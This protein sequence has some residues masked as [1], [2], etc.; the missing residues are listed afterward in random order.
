MKNYII[1]FTLCVLTFFSCKKDSSIETTSTSAFS[2][3]ST[4]GVYIS[5]EGLF[6]NGNGSVS[7]YS[8]SGTESIKDVYQQVNNTQLGDVVQSLAKV[9]NKLYIVVNNSSKIEV[10][11]ITTMKKTATISGLTSPRY[12]LP[13]NASK[14]YVTDLFSGS[15]SIVDLN[16][17]LVTGHISLN[18][19]TEQLIMYNGKVYVTNMSTSYLYVIN[20]TTDNVSDS[21]LIGTGGNSIVM[22]KN[23]KLWILCGGD[24]NLNIT[25][26]LHRVDPI[27]Q[28]DEF[29]VDFPAATF[30]NRLTINEAKD[31]LY[32][33]NY[34]LYR[35]NILDTTLPGSEFIAAN[36]KNFYGLG[37]NNT[38]NQIY[39]SDGVDFQQAGRVYRYNESGTE[40][41][42]FGAGIIPGN[43]LFLGN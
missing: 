39:V 20:P 11:D 12:L 10:V 40:L 41:G 16:T 2:A 15:V 1:L 5:N 14:A 37:F 27:T 25:S 6:N 22:D 31:E 21:I 28:I 34:N 18:G 8:G 29:G 13:I 35:M 23:N 30:I 9:N 4:S 3:S 43:F 42:S 7:Y 24:Y 17:N 33:L 19:S 36:G 26:S 32:F 38:L